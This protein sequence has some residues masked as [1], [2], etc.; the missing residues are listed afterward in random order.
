MRTDN[1]I[2]TVLKNRVTFGDWYNVFDAA[3]KFSHAER[4]VY[5]NNHRQGVVSIHVEDAKWH[6]GESWYRLESDNG[7]HTASA[8]LTDL[9]QFVGWTPTGC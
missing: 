8:L 2:P 3:G 6:E 9:V 1:F 4:V 7:Y 5:L